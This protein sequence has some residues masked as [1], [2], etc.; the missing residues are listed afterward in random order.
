M[1]PCKPSSDHRKRPFNAGR[2]PLRMK[3]FSDFGKGVVQEMQIP[4]CEMFNKRPE[5]IDD[6]SLIR[7][8]WSIL[9]RR[10]RFGN[11]SNDRLII[12]ESSTGFRNSKPACSSSSHFLRTANFESLA[13]TSS[14]SLT[15]GMGWNNFALKPFAETSRTTQTSSLPADTNF[16]VRN[17]SF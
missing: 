13:K 4:C 9:M 2:S 5:I 6:P 11:W 17:N 7:A 3:S 8:P 12:S 1:I 10:P 14:H 16:P 15:D